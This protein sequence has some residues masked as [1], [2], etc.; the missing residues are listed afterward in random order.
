VSTH[1][2]NQ[3]TVDRAV[4][5]LRAESR[6]VARW[7][8]KTDD[9]TDSHAGRFETSCLL[10]I[11]PESVRQDRFEP[12]NTSPIS[13]LMPRLRRSG[14]SGVSPSGVLGDPTGASASLGA[15]LLDRWTA[16]LVLTARA[17]FP[18]IVNDSAG[19]SRG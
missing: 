18:A 1:G 16:D 2:G 11:Q 10:A 14:I 13:E 15:E 5:R 8:P 9:P 7:S 19:R 6:N 4:T 12:G 17:N 3:E